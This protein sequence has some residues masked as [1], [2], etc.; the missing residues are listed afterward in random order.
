MIMIVVSVIDIT[1]SGVFSVT[2]TGV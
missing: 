1:I 2:W